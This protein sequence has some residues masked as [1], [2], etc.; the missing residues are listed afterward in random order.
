MARK[1]LG[2]TP[3]LSKL[4][5]W[6]AAA[7][8]ASGKDRDATADAATI[9]VRTLALIADYPRACMEFSDVKG[10]GRSVRSPTPGEGLPSFK[11]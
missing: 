2:P 10:N 5:F 1:P 3:G 4:P 11:H 9:N 8:D 7:A 6:K